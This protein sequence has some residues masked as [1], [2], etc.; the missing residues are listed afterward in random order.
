MLTIDIYTKRMREHKK[1]KC[2]HYIARECIEGNW[3]AWKLVG[4]RTVKEFVSNS[5]V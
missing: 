1:T 3:S 5:G 4:V 2:G